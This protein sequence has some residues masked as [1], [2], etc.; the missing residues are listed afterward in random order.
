[1]KAAYRNV[2]GKDPGR[3]ISATHY[4]IK[5][6]PK[7]YKELARLEEED[8]ELF[9]YPLHRALISEGDYYIQPGKQ[10][11][12]IPDY[13]S[14]VDVNYKMPNRYFLSNN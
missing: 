10:V 14:V 11:E 3:I 13:Y 1:M 9:D 8:I 12:D 5:F 4:Y 2:Y 6:S 7:N